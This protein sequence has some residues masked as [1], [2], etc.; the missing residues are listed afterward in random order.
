MGRL[1]VNVEVADLATVRSLWYMVD[2]G[3]RGS[4]VSAER[5]VVELSSERMHSTRDGRRL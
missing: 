2:C 3:W 5:L 4:L 1:K